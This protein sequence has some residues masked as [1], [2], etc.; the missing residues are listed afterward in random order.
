MLAPPI[1]H[2]LLRGLQLLALSLALLLLSLTTSFSAHYACAELE[3]FLPDVQHDAL[4]L[5]I[6]LYGPPFEMLK[7]LITVAFFT[8]S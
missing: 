6:Y 5:K 3:L 2:E 7:V 4:N 8:E 1:A